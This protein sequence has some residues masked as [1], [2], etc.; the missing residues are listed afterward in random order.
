MVW[1]TAPAAVIVNL[2]L[3]SKLLPG[4]AIEIGVA[5]AAA[6]LLWRWAK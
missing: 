2:V 1:V 4:V 3:L 6:C 5:A